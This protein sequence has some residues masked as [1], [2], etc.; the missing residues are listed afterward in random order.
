MEVP[1][2]DRV[3]LRRSQLRCGVDDLMRRCGCA[4]EA[5][6]LELLEP[7]AHHRRAARHVGA[8]SRIDGQLGAEVERVQ[9]SQELAEGST[10]RDPRVV[11][12]RFLRELSTGQERSTVERPL[13]GLGRLA[14]VRRPRDRQRE[15]V[16]QL[17]QV[18]HLQLEARDDHR[19][20][21]EAKD[22][23]AVD[24]PDHVVPALAE[25]G[26]LVSAEVGK[27]LRDQPPRECFVDAD[28]GVP[29]VHGG[30]LRGPA[31]V[32]RPCDVPSS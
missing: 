23:T 19:A 21:R 2:D 17:R 18:P 1:V 4:P 16:G 27:L 29:L 20:S 5:G 14:Q 11:V 12:Q 32:E 6:L 30:K 24:Q 7:L 9:R 13:E 31:C 8:L 15:P 3:R 28:F 25:E 22:P 10:Q 26:Q